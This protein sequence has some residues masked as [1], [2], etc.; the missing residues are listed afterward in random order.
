MEGSRFGREEIQE[1]LDKRKANDLHE[2]LN[3][4]LQECTK[5][6]E[7]ITTYRLQRFTKSR[8]TTRSL[9]GQPSLKRGS[10]EDAL[11]YRSIS[12][13]SEVR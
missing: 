10:R 12:L 4:V 7:C 8:K 9:Q 3:R 11:N 2:V 1:I 13:I 5:R 6:P